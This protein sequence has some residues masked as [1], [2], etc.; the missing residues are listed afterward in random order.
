[1]LKLKQ[2]LHPTD[3]TPCAEAALIHAV[4]IATRLEAELHLLHVVPRLGPNTFFDLDGTPPAAASESERWDGIIQQFDAMSDA[5]RDVLHVHRSGGYGPLAGP[6]IVEY[7]AEAGVDLI[8][9]GTCRN[10]L[11]EKIKLGS[12]AREV[13]HR[14][15]CPVLTVNRSKVGVGPVRIAHVMA[16][17]DEMDS[18]VS[19]IR[20]A[21]EFAQMYNAK[22]SLVH[23]LNG[24]GPSVARGA[25]PEE[26]AEAVRKHLN[27]RYSDAVHQLCEQGIAVEQVE[28][29]NVHVLSGPQ[30]KQIVRF[31]EEQNVDL[32]VFTM[33]KP[34]ESGDADL[35]EYVAG[36][37]PC[38]VMSINE[39]GKSRIEVP[40]K[41]SQER[42]GTG[43][44]REVADVGA[45][46]GASEP[47]GLEPG[48]PEA[49]RR[50]NPRKGDVA[51]RQKLRKPI[52]KWP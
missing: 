46:T 33:R 52:Q 38:A 9:M 41:P 6:A 47:L 50:R 25:A 34:I 7:A 49:N 1:M 22:L 48:V 4:E 18:I 37:A 32:V 24:K 26:T 5:W 13:I 21:S 35:V 27:E 44:G 51:G 23:V 31:I 43:S 11:E 39:I 16:P 12:A 30:G 3:L 36:R 20:Y 10:G 40:P 14:A 28:D 17:I 29:V 2:I 15:P 8:V 45:G 19:E 42:E